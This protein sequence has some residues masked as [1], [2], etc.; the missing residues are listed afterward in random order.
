V[1]TAVQVGVGVAHTDT[2]RSRIKMARIAHRQRERPYATEAVLV[3][4]AKT[5]LGQYIGLGQTQ[6]VPAGTSTPYTL[7]VG[8]TGCTH[9]CS[10][11]PDG[12]LTMQ[13]TGHF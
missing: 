1:G 7:A 11:Y 3:V 8:V 5:L 10:V 2:G 4:E 9:T 6:D 12:L 13:R